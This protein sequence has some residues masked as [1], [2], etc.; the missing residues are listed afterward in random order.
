MND[1]SE[2]EIASIIATGPRAGAYLDT[3]GKTDLAALTEQEWL[4]FIATTV[5]AY[6]EEMAK[7]HAPYAV[8][9]SGHDPASDGFMGY[10]QPALA[11]AGEP[12]RA[13]EV[14]F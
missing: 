1:F 6:A 2:N 11:A 9:R 8:L 5:M 12:I 13:D 14:P 10:P 7:R 3:L 4:E